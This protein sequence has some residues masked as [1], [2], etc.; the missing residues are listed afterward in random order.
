MF[1][2]LMTIAAFD[3]IPTDYLYDKYI[4]GP[5]DGDPITPDFEAVG[6]ETIWFLPNLGSFALVIAAI[7]F[8]Y[9]LYFLFAIC[10]K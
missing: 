8:I 5:Q 3:V 10:R 4:F 1:G 9:L 7:P 2:I 6:F